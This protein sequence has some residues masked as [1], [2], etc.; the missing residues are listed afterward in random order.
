[1]YKLI[2]KGYDEDGED[3]V[4]LQRVGGA[5]IPAVNVFIP[6]LLSRGSESPRASRYSPRVLR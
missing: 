6:S 3:R 2:N 1:M 5:V 4:A